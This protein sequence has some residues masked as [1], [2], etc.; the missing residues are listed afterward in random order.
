[1]PRNPR[2]GLTT[3]AALAAILLLAVLTL[4]LRTLRQPTSAKCRFPLD[5]P[6]RTPYL[7]Q[8]ARW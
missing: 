1:M 3:L 2:Q 8:H 4:T 5:A 7:A 6:R